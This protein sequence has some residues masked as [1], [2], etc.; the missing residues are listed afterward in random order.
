LQ[1][2][3]SCLNGSAKAKAIYKKFQALQHSQLRH[4]RVLSRPAHGASIKVVR[5]SRRHHESRFPRDVV[6]CPNMQ[7][8]N[9]RTSINGPPFGVGSCMRRYYFSRLQPDTQIHTTA[10]AWLEQS[11]RLLH[12]G[13]DFMR[14]Q[15]V[16]IGA[17]GI[18]ERFYNKNF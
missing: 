18:W 13:F 11:T 10:F 7:C 2:L 5:Y 9:Q 12:K 4:L 17:T 3:N 8:I 14:Q 1:L 15:I 16:P 6:I